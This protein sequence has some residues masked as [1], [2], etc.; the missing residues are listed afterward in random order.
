MKG[1]QLEVYEV[2]K[3]PSLFSLTMREIVRD[4]L[5]LAG[6]IILFLVLA[7][8]IIASPIITTDVATRIDIWNT[9]QPPSWVE[10]GAEGFLLGTE[11]GGRN[12]LYL[13]IISTR[14]SII[15][16]LGV[17]IISLLVG[18]IVGLIA[19][20]Y[21]GH[22]DAVIMRLVETWTMIPSLLFTIVLIR[23]LERNI[24]NMILIL[25]IFGWTGMARMIR[26]ITLQQRNME[27][28]MASKTMGTRNIV[29][30]FREVVPNIMPVLAPMVVLGI[31]ATIGVETTLSMIGFG[32]PIGTPSIGTI[33][34]SA[35]DFVNLQHRWWTWLPGIVV[36]FLVSISINF[37]G[38]AI[39]RVADPRQRVV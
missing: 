24:P 35:M 19:G 2:V 3:I 25:V 21:A 39:Q 11:A 17:A 8:V 12:M 6:S 4:K 31:S 29:I 5:A 28:V 34:N 14:N 1:D 38:S 37:V 22:V 30:M 27:F 23:T 13:L 32:L 26:T 33:V 36:L 15:I 20:Y 7:T 9:N 18:F 10:G 16:G